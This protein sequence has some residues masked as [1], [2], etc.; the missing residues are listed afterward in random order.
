MTE[1]IIPS[2]LH[3]QGYLAQIAP[4]SLGTNRPR[5]H[6]IWLHPFIDYCQKFHRGRFANSNPALRTTYHR[7]G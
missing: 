3:P 5:R 6:L 2:P 1:L 4:L 7:N